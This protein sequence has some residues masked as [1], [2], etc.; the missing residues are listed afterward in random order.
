MAAEPE[1]IT[2]EEAAQYLR[3]CEKT[4]Y[5][6][7]RDGKIRAYRAGRAWRFRRVDL[8]GWLL[9]QQNQSD[10][11][12]ADVAAAIEAEEAEEE[13]STET[14]SVGARLAE[15]RARNRERMIRGVGREEIERWVKA[16]RKRLVA[17]E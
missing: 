3:V 9:A 14:P 16:G 6:W 7:L 1:L 4:L 15:L 13:G 17:V 2:I 12:L 10:V 8:D 5:R 11:D